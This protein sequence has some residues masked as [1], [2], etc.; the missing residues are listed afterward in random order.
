MYNSTTEI[1][2]LEEVIAVDS[3]K[4]MGP[5]NT[6]CTNYSF[7]ILQEGGAYNNHRNR[8]MEIIDNDI[9]S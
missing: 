5:T 7:F 2:L 4:H 8:Q 3:E 9:W 1:Y 6:Q